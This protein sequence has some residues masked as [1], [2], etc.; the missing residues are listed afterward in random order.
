MRLL[1]VLLFFLS[2]GWRCSLA[3]AGLRKGRLH[4]GT[5]VEEA[6][7]QLL[8]TGLSRRLCVTVR[9][10]AQALR[11]LISHFVVA[12]RVDSTFV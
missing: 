10:D 12:W 8:S 4:I 11:A 3:H 5:P 7:Q 6:L 2:L 9:P 1:S